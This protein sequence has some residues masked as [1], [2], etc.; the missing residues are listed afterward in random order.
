MGDKEQFFNRNI[1]K[2]AFDSIHSH[3]KYS[4]LGGSHSIDKK[5]RKLKNAN[6]FKKKRTKATSSSKKSD[7]VAPANVPFTDAVFMKNYR[8]TNLTTNK[9]KNAS[10]NQ[11]EVIQK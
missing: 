5:R 9:G 4:S 11:N 1:D 10:N 7:K 3:S 8:S 2:T 6:S